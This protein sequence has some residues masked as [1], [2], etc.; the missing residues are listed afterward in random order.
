MVLL[1]NA[2]HCCVST[3]FALHESVALAPWDCLGTGCDAERS[4]RQQCYP[5]PFSQTELLVTLVRH[6]AGLPA[7]CTLI[8]R[9]TFFGYWAACCLYPYQQTQVL[10]LTTIGHTH[11]HFWGAPR[12]KAAGL[13]GNLQG[14]MQCCVVLRGCVRHAGVG[15][16]LRG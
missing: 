14:I 16:P 2:F 13:P 5:P 9:H 8:S 4:C 7:A 15:V 11:K 3:G 10:W 1:P 12:G 6:W